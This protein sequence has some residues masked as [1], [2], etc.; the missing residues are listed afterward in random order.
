MRFTK[1]ISAFAL[2]SSALAV[3][4]YQAVELVKRFADSFLAPNNVE[5]AKKGNR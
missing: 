5:I 1:L 2:A 3:T 4:E